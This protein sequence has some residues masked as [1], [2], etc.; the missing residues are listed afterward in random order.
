MAFGV[1]SVSHPSCELSSYATGWDEII[2]KQS[3]FGN[4]DYSSLFAPSLDR[5]HIS[6]IQNSSSGYSFLK[7]CALGDREDV[8]SSSLHNSSPIPGSD[9]KKLPSLYSCK[10]PLLSGYRPKFTPYNWEPSI[11]FR[12][13]Y[14]FPSLS[15]S[16]PA[17]QYDPLRDS[18]EQPDGGNKT[19]R[20]SS[21]GKA[22]LFHDTSHGGVNDDKGLPAAEVSESK[23]D[24]N[25]LESHQKLPDGDWDKNYHGSSKNAPMEEAESAATSATETQNRGAMPEGETIK[26]VKD[27]PKEVRMDYG[28]DPK[29]QND[30]VRLKKVIKMGKDVRSGELEMDEYEEM[31]RELKAMKHFR[32]SVVEFVKELMK[33]IWHEGNLSKD[34]YKVVV[35]KVEEKIV[36]SLLPSQVPNTTEL[37]KQYLASSRPKILNLMEGYVEKYGNV[38]KYGKL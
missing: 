35:Q 16:S 7:V 8:R 20:L 3:R 9:A 29:N 23:V 24:M 11:P 21:S 36:S 4:N 33:P 18:I 12:P 31:H 1:S 38:E 10:D 26:R 2:G 34:A 15:R 28:T 37:V 6:G 13:S 30:R 17:S 27:K 32:A 22:S 19:L 25:H 5:H 14:F